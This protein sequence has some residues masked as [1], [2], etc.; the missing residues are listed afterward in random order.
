L[1]LRLFQLAL[2]GLLLVAVASAQTRPGPVTPPPQAPA[3]T[4]GSASHIRPPAPGYRYPE[5]LTYV[6]AVDWRLW[7]AGTATLHIESSGAQQKVSGTADSIGFAAVLFTVRDRFDS[8]FD[9]ATFCSLSLHKQTQEGARGRDTWI[10]FDY[11]AGKRL[12]DE[13]NLKT[14]QSKHTEA[15]IPACVTDVLSGIYYL[16]SLPLAVGATYYFPLNDGGQTVDVKARVEAREQIKT[17][18]GTFQALRVQ[19]EA[20]SGVLKD[21][22]RVWIWYSDDAAHIPVQARARMFWGT[23][24]IHLV[25]V[26]HK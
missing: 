6:Y 21:R 10:R 12:L 16:A 11:L 18:A 4:I 8:L 26:E 20:A 14:G 1:P 7:S 25:R 23:L 15:P 5:K 3:A 17:E 9:P 19:P 24:T 2:G 13:K 22:G